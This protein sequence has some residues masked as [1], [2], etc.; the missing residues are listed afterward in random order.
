MIVVFSFSTV[1]VLALPR[2]ATSID[3]SFS[4]RSS[5]TNLAPVRVAMSLSISLRRSPK[6]GALTAQTLSTP[7]SLLTTRAARASP[8]TSSAITSSSLPVWATF[9][10]SGRNSRRLLIFFS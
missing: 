8:S 6:P 7:R 4:P 9:S 1:T 5:A 10:S 2:S 3:S